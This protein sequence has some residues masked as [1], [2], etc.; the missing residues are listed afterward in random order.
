MMQI[1]V[2]FFFK[3]KNTVQTENFHKLR[4]DQKKKGHDGGGIALGAPN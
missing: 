3:Q 2:Q 4:S 1:L